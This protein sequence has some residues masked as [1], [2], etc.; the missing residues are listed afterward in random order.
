MHISRTF[1]QHTWHA[2]KVRVTSKC[3]ARRDVIDQAGSTRRARTRPAGHQP[4]DGHCQLH[5]TPDKA[6]RAR[7]WW[8]NGF[9]LVVWTDV[10]KSYKINKIPIYTWPMLPLNLQKKKSMVVPLLSWFR[11]IHLVTK[12]RKSKLKDHP[13]LRSYQILA[14]RVLCI[15]F[16]GEKTCWWQKKHS[17]PSTIRNT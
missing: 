5:S 2:P 10:Y 6:T 16:T 7:K 3:V 13:N 4:N 8:W 9:Y 14:P 1:Y 17:H 12:Q 11:I 15:N